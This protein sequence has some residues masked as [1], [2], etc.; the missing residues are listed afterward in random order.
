MAETTVQLELTIDVIG[1]PAPQ[2][3]KSYKGMRNGKP[4]LAESS[5]KVKP[6]R[7][8]VDKAARAR[9]ALT[10]W[11]TL[12]GPVAGEAW[13]Y[14]QPPQKMPPERIV[15]GIAYPACYPDVTKLIRSTEDALKTAGV[16]LDDGQF[17]DWTIHKRYPTTGLVGARIIVRSVT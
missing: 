6:W 12:A 11:Q 14:L 13:F 2:G 16:V 9:I 8:L 10:G 15:N 1:T 7:V 4:I 17:V 3:S 5:E